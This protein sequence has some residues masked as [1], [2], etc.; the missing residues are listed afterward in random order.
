M[1]MRLSTSSLLTV[2][3]MFTTETVTTQGTTPDS[4]F[5]G[6]WRLVSTQATFK[7]GTKGPIPYLGPRGKAYL[8]YTPDQHMCAVLMNPQRPLW[9]SAATPTE[10]EAK[11]AVDGFYAYC[12][13]FEIQEKENIVVHRLEV[14]LTPN[15]VGERWRRVYR[16]EGDTLILRPLE[17][18]PAFTGGALTWERVR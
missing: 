8:I 16:F 5:V 10:K 12:G 14:A 3:M 11:A 7:D 15:D 2:L 9:S 13:T 6:T 4:R 18:D 1:H 17:P